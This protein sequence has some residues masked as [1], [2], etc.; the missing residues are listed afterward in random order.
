MLIYEVL[1]NQFIKYVGKT[2][3]ALD[4]KFHHYLK[5]KEWRFI[6]IRIIPS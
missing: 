3:Q 5:Y 1:T 2:E 6:D 4:F